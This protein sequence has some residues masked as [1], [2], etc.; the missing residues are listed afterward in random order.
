MLS[1]MMMMIITKI[2]IREYKISV[3]TVI[4]FS[5]DFDDDDDDDDGDDVSAK[6]F[7]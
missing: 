2:L 6:R 3:Q 4:I 1:I 7:S 5:E